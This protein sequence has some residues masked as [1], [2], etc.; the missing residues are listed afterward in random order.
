[1]IKIAFIINAVYANNGGT[2]KQLLMLLK[3]LNRD[4]FSPT[5]C[6]L[7]KSEWVEKEFDLC[8]VYTIGAQSLLDPKILIKFFN[9]CRFLSHEGFDIVQTHFSEANKIGI[10]AAKITGVQRIIS[11]RRNQW[12]LTSYIERYILKLL[13]NYVDRFVAN[14]ISTADLV[15]NVEGI[16]QEKVKVIHNAID[17]ERFENI[18]SSTHS[19]SRDALSIPENALVV[20]I[21]ANLREIKGLDIFIHAARKVKNR[22]PEAVFLVVGSNV[23]YEIEERKLHRLTKELGLSDSLHFLGERQDVPQL[24]AA[25]DIAVLTSRSEGF[26][27]SLIEYVAAGLPVVTTD[28]GGAR[29]AVIDGINGMIVPVNDQEAVAKAIICIAEGCLKKEDILYKKHEAHRKYSSRDMVNE[30]ENLYWELSKS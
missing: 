23:G 3:N 1:M 14:S 10:I 20:G 22:Y 30:Y 2:E 5:L 4:K 24:L 13:N 25:F 11:T 19:N 6:I 21:V 16:P 17:M 9:F 28:V 7:R 29:E 18:E 12:Y 8:P 15:I 26:S 27:N